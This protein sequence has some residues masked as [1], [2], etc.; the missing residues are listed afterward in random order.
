VDLIL[1]FALA[2]TF[3]VSFNTWHVLK[4]RREMVQ[5]GPALG[6]AF[7]SLQGQLEQIAD[8]PEVLKGVGGV[9]LMPQ[10]SFGEIMVEHITNHFFGGKEDQPLS[11]AQ[12]ETQAWPPE[13]SEPLLADG[14]SKVSE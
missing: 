3:I 8:L 14:N 5:L 2:S 7:Q 12:P 9:Q 6:G 1:L 13:E 10:K 4:L 11:N